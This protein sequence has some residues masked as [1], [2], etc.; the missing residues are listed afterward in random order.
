MSTP[1]EALVMFARTG[2]HA[3]AL[4][5]TLVWK[6]ANGYGR[7]V[8]RI[9]P[10][11]GGGNATHGIPTVCEASLVQRVRGR[12]AHHAADVLDAAAV[13]SR[14]VRAVRGDPAHGRRHSV[15]RER[16][17]TTCAAH[18]LVVL[19]RATSSATAISIERTSGARAAPRRSSRAARAR[20]LTTG[21]DP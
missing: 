13:R 11:A 7:N 18:L 6:D 16:D 2:M 1:V 3:L 4:G 5:N 9:G 15:D 8:P 10:R 12:A 14:R 17:C 21:F 20:A 19:T